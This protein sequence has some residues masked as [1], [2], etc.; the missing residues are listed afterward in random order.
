MEEY[1]PRNTRKYAGKTFVTRNESEY[2]VTEDGRI[3]GRRSLEGAKIELLAGL[4]EEFYWDA[5]AYIQEF[6][7]T[8]G[9]NIRNWHPLTKAQFIESKIFLSN[10]LLS[11]QGD[12]VSMAHSVEGRY[13]FLDHNFIQFCCQLPPQLKLKGLNEKYLLKK[14]FN[15]IIP[16]EILKRDKHPYRA[17]IVQS[18]FVNNGPEYVKELLSEK[19]LEEKGYFRTKA[20]KKL[21]EK[22]G[23]SFHLGEVD[24]MAIAGILSVQLLDE[25]FLK[26]F[27]NKT[28]NH[29]TINVNIH[30]QS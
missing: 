26:N 12:R 15:K 11:S 1:D 23:K 8:L 30:K 19:Q 22:W 14:T 16:Q 18:F 2:S 21:I 29:S 9:K 25:M 20:V 28:E 27:T 17:P 5:V 7:K 6:E 10:Y 3:S 4:K 13:P 24:E